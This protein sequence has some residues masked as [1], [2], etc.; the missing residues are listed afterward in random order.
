MTSAAW[1]GN[2]A[3][4]KQVYKDAIKKII[5][6]YDLQGTAMEIRPDEHEDSQYNIWVRTLKARCE[7]K[8]NQFLQLSAIKMDL[9]P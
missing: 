8:C 4:M 5:V 6:K 3:Q 7:A 1:T 2:F 9:H